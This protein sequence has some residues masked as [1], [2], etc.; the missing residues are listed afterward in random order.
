MHKMNRQYQKMVFDAILGKK[1]IIQLLNK[2]KGWP[3]YEINQM[4]TLIMSKKTK[5]TQALIR[6][7]FPKNYSELCP[8]KRFKF[9]MTCNIENIIGWYTEIIKCFAKEIV[10]Y[11]ELKASYYNY[12][13]N[14]NYSEAREKFEIIKSIGCSLWSLENEFILAEYEDGLEKNKN[15]LSKFE[16]MGCSVWITFFAN[17]FSFKAEKGITNR[18]YLYRIE[19]VLEGTPSEIAAFVEEKMFPI[20][21]IKVNLIKEIL[22]FNSGTSI[23]DIFDSFIRMGTWVMCS[24]EINVSTKD[25]FSDAFSGLAGI[26]NPTI[27]KIL[28]NEK[29]YTLTDID[30]RMYDIGNDYTEG[31]YETAIANCR[32]IFSQEGI[33][34]EAIEYF[35]K[36]HIMLNLEIGEEYDGSILGDLISA[37]YN[38]YLH[39]A[40]VKKSLDDLFR[41]ERIASNVSM[42]SAVASFIIDK[43]TTDLAEVQNRIK[44]YQSPFLNIKF[45]I[46][47]CGGN[48][49]SQMAT[50]FK[51]GS[52]LDLFLANENRE[53]LTNCNIEYNRQR[54]YYLKSL[55]DI[56]LKICELEKWY[57]EIRKNEDSFSVYMTERIATELFYSYLDCNKIVCAEEIFVTCYLRNRYSV[58]RMNLDKLPKY[59]EEEVKASI[60]TP[61]IAYISS[62]DYAKIFSAL[63]NFLDRSRFSKPS[64]LKDY[65]QEYDEAVLAFFLGKVCTCEILDSFYYVYSSNE[66]VENERLSIC[67]FLQEFDVQNSQLYINEISEILK[68]RKIMQGIKYI[69]KVKINLDFQKAISDKQAIFMDNLRRFIEIGNLDIE[70]KAIDLAKQLIYIRETEEKEK[71]SFKLSLLSEII[72]D[73]QHELAFG[74]YGLDQTL[75]TRIR[76]GILQNQIRSVF[77]KND[78]VFV[79]KNVGD[80]NYIIPE[81]FGAHLGN[82]SDNDKKKI[83]PIISAFSQ[84]I[85]EYILELREKNVQIKI[86]E[87]H[88]DGLID[89]SIGTDE[90]VAMYEAA[91]KI[92]SEIMLM[93]AFEEFWMNKINLCLDNARTFFSCFVKKRFIQIIDELEIELETIENEEAKLYFHDRVIQSRTEIQSTIDNVANWFRLPFKKEYPAFDIQTLVE[94]CEAINQK[95]LSGYENINKNINI[96]NNIV[97]K[98]EYF[99]Y[100]VDIVNILITNSYMH[101]GFSRD[102]SNLFIDFSVYLKNDRIYFDIKN[103][104]SES[105]DKEQLSDRIIEIQRIIQEMMQK[106]Q[107]RS[108]EGGSGFVK[109]SK[110]LQWDIEKE[111]N[112]AFG[113]DDSE[114]HF[115]VEVSINQNGLIIHRKES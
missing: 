33:F 44:E 101:A 109:I 76:H 82:L 2:T 50:L 106:D 90:L 111:W 40:E 66:E 15:E 114:T 7:L 21:S 28:F 73:F 60:F 8:Y 84:K 80:I 56:S 104:L 13:F 49:V 27:K 38:S 53:E 10:Q 11:Q 103:N 54:W 81:G 43:Y 55:L 16:T 14:S 98:G 68:K 86:N 24:D 19:R 107:F 23:F 99:S 39:N 92:D 9:D 105:V 95:V 47:R 102:L 59:E 35:V 22:L 17:L 20:D 5:S 65:T 74:K 48:T 62:S 61:I 100:L 30:K 94:T 77:E 3:E 32:D 46:E 110:I 112:V 45:G 115:F 42:G 71:Y 88:P 79:K 34:F 67:A 70:Y 4:L 75:G 31:K 52:S 91:Q 25:L 12:L 64:E 69:E 108:F 97:I 96:D 58:I 78:I 18:Q 37:M 113:L 41:I 87:L 72:K 83:S 63:A 89:L 6:S 26:N 36:S 51:E 1:D 29:S 85:D 57:E 93:D